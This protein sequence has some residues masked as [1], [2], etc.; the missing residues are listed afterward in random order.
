MS[1]KELTPGREAHL[2]VI[3]RWKMQ[4]NK[5]LPNGELTPEDFV[6]NAK[7]EELNRYTKAEKSVDVVVN[8]IKEHFGVE[9][10]KDEKPKFTVSHTD[11]TY[12]KIVDI[13]AAVHDNWVFENPGR[14]N[15]NS[16]SSICKHL[17]IECAGE[18]F[19]AKDLLFVAPFFKN[20]GLD[21]GRF[22]NQKFELGEKIKNAYK[23]RIEKFKYLHGIEDAAS[24]LKAIGSLISGDYKP[25][26][27]KCSSLS[28][29]NGDTS[30]E[31]VFNRISEMNKNIEKMAIWI[32]SEEN[33]DYNNY[34][35][36]DIDREIYGE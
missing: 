9:V 29:Q 5:I 12:D 3:Y 22:Y 32:S 19:F 14:Y 7:Y 1:D 23:R 26:Q 31:D 2:Y 28:I 17:P 11:E 36:E 16:T 35:Q 8:K 33:E 6:A 15:P 13:V 25:L 18:K 30:E 21:L 4:Y 20:L 24:L 34:D 27:P 10:E